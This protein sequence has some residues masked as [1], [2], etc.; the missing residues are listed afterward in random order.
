[1]P[2]GFVARRRESYRV[3]FVDRMRFGCALED[4]VYTLYRNSVTV[5]GRIKSST[6][7]EEHF[8]LP[9]VLLA[10]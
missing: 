7:E 4:E 3:I 1:M 5:E 9:A 2:R 8:H 6:C 10:A